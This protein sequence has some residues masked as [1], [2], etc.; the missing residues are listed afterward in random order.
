MKASVYTEYGPPDVLQVREVEKPVPKDDEVLIK[1]YATT[2]N[3]ND[4][5]FRSAEYF[6]IRFFFGLSKPKKPILGTELAGVV[7]AVGRGVTDFKAGDEVFGITGGVRFGAHAEYICLPQ[8]APIA[9]KPVN[10]SMLEAAAVCDGMTMAYNYIGKIDFSKEP[11]I[12]IYGASGSIG[13]AA[14]QLARYFGA[15][16][17][18]VCGTKNLK[19]VKSL[20]ADKAVDYTAQDFTQDELRYDVV[21]DAV[22][23]TSFSRCKKLLKP[24]GT[25]FSTDLGPHAENIYLPLFTS[26]AGGKKVRFPLPKETKEQIVFFKKIIEEGKYRAVIDRTYP[27]EQIVEATRYVETQQKTGN[28]VISVTDADT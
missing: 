25:Y 12:L 23:K 5:G 4:C 9:A 8:S 2:V 7:E 28:V 19:L 10:M 14:V 18:A 13:T 11:A 26:L 3:R 21:L 17:T 27:L 16:I 15:K 1:I 6:F 22:G 20:G 24:G